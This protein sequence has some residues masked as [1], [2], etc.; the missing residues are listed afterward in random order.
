MASFIPEEKIRDIENATDIVEIISESVSLKRTGRNY[1]GLCPFHSEKAPSFSVNPD[2][3]IFY[4]FGCQAGGN[5]FS[6]L[7]KNENMSFPEA[8]RSLAKRYNIDIPERQLSPS[9]KKRIGEKEDLL[10]INERAMNYFHWVLKN[11]GGKRA[12]AYLKKRGMSDTIIDTF[13]IGYAPPGW[14]NLI[15]LLHQKRVP[16]GIAEKS[17]LIIPRNER[18]GHYDRFRD[19]I[20]FPIFDLRSKVVGFG[21]RVMDDSLPKYL[22]SPESPVFDKSR[23]LYGLHLAKKACRQSGTVFI[24]EGYFDVLSMYQHGVENTVATL[25]TSLTQA[26]AR[27]IKGYAKRVVLVFDSDAAGVKAAHRGIGIFRTE[28]LDTR[29]L[30]L[31]S[32][33]DPDSFMVERGPEEFEK[34]AEGAFSVIAFLT[35]SAVKKHGLSVEGK[36]RIIS[37]LREILGTVQDPVERSLYMKQFAERI[38]VEES[39]IIEKFGKHP[40]SIRDTAPGPGRHAHPAPE[41]PPVGKMDRFERS[42]LSMALQFPEILSDI[43]ERDVLADFENPDYRAIGQAVLDRM[44]E[45]DLRISEIVAGFQDERLNG[46]A[47]S[48]MIEENSWDRERCLKLIGQFQSVKRRANKDLN[49]QIIAAERRNDKELRDKLL[50]EKIIRARRLA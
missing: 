42:I 45:S 19:R 47:A 9:E 27:S 40:P 44:G 2:K 23:S 20:I 29:I 4:C 43:K 12:M 3:R 50:K 22:N 17:G 14:D 15:R 18:N 38:D 5:V 30:V 8:V 31:P 35:E 34:L 25:G 26:H 13:R 46:L 49:K 28:N 36:L 41:N 33:Y 39:A 16:L 7:M 10:K 24:T 48:L 37:E 11:S 21:G 6:F 32:G 1:T